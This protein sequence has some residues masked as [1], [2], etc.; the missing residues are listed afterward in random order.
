[1]Q[2][3]EAIQLIQSPRFAGATQQTWAD[4]GC[5]AGTFTLA[6]AA[7]LAPPGLI[8][9]MDQDEVALRHIP[10]QHHQ[11]A[12]EKRRADFVTEDL[13]LENL[14]G[15]LMANA[16]H[17]VKDKTVL[18]QKL[19]SYLHENGCFIIVEYET[20]RANPWVPYPIRFQ[21][22]KQLFTT[23]GYPSIEKLNEIPSRYHGKMYAAL[24][25]K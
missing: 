25:Q 24:I 12:I 18:T 10:N 7:L 9:A 19:Q 2:A 13:R 8:Y 14:D 3:K 17:Y 20:D 4:L 23:I 21:A 15:I 6:L 22:L 16:L 11:V 5:G 1:M